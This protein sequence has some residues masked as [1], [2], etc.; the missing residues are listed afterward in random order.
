MSPRAGSGLGSAGSA[1]PPAFSPSGVSPGSR[2][3]PL[4]TAATS[5]GHANG[6]GQSSPTVPGIGI[7]GPSRSPAQGAFQPNGI[8]AGR[9]GTAST[10]TSPTTSV[11]DKLLAM[12]QALLERDAQL[13]LAQTQEGLE[14][15]QLQESSAGDVGGRRRSSALSAQA[16]LGYE[17]QPGLG[18]SGTRLALERMMERDKDLPKNS[19]IL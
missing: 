8:G 13:V 6:S 17:V 3:A 7:P 11:R 16:Q 1:L 5:A 15:M 9:Y 14:E 19:L 4:G 18:T 2:A 10:G 12:R